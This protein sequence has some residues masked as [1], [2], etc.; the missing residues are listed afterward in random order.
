[1]CSM[2][3]IIGKLKKRKGKFIESHGSIVKEN[4][5]G[6][7]TAKVPKKNFSLWQLTLPE[8]RCLTAKEW[9]KTDKE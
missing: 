1:M 4:Q 5:C 6:I 7:L 3:K 2:K 9:L 8:G